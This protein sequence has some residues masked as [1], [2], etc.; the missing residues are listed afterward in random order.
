[1]ANG[2][3]AGLVWEG[4]DSWYPHHLDWS[5]WGLLA[6]DDKNA[7]PKTYTPRKSFYTM[8]QIT[9]FVRPGARRIGLNGSLGSLELLAFYHYEL[10]QLTLTGINTA[11]SGGLLAGTLQSL[12]GINSLDL[13]YT[14]SATNL[15]HSAII[16][17][18]NGA[19]QVAVP[20]DCIFTLTG[21][22]PAKLA[23]SLQITNPAE[24]AHYSAPADILI[25]AS[26]D[27][28]TGSVSK[29]E[30]FSDTNK[31]GEVNG[32]AEAGTPYSLTWSSVGPGAYVLSARASN[33][34]GN[35]G[36]SSNVHVV[37]VGPLAQIRVTPEMMWLGQGEVCNLMR[38]QWMFW[39]S[40]STRSLTSFGQSTAA[41][42][43]GVMDY[44]RQELALEAHLG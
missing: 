3:S 18:T 21:F 2:A 37:V 4:Y 27:S 23:V 12:P 31:L 29:V 11:G 36:V 38:S 40:R 34:V 7:F 6:V 30:F 44:F 5:F 14:D 26:A 17:V 9:K 43:L 1:L 33:S 25:Q 13:Y 39:E 24:G 15:A 41:A 42:I 22:D 35:I 20:G 32:P 19:F 10:G 28:S 16:P 8:A